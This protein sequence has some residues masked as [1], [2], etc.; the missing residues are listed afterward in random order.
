MAKQTI[1]IGTSD[2]SGDGESIRNAFDKCNDNFTEN[3]ASIASIEADIATLD[4]SK[5][6]YGDLSVTTAA[7]SG[8]GALTYNSATGVFTFTPAASVAETNDLT[9]SVTWAN[10]PDANITESSVTQHQAALTITESQI[11]DLSHTSYDQDLNTTDS[12]QFVG[13]TATGNGT[14]TGTL[15]VTGGTNFTGTTYHNGGLS[16]SNG[17]F[18]GTID[19][20]TIQTS[21]GNLSIIADNYVFIDSDRDGS[22]VIGRNSGVGNVVL[23][24]T[25]NDTDVVF[26]GNVIVKTGIAGLDTASSIAPTSFT[27][28]AGNNTGADLFNAANG[29]SLTLQGGSSGFNPGGALNLFG[30]D[31][32]VDG[33]INIGTSH[34]STINVGATIDMGTNTITDTKVGQWDTAYGWG[35][36]SSAG[37]LS[38]ITVTTD[39]YNGDYNLVFVPGSG[40]KTNVRVDSTGS[41]TWNPNTNVLTLDGETITSTKIGQWDDAYG[42]G[43]H[44]AE[45]YVPSDTAGITGADQVT[46]IVTLTQAEYDAIGS[47]NASTVYIIVG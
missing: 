39:D 29:G 26:E 19:T 43:D 36:H 24:N 4:G 38:A 10:V 47:P 27:I 17:T 5:I 44:S 41:L 1:N 16:S 30:G 40:N 6:V 9:A 15:A 14:I 22:I 31:G 46:N 12:V 8:A 23:G 13:I 45:N 37:Y 7:A 28:R 35:D 11:S 3:Y 34:T 20:N 33:D 2:T 42:W 25:A 18:S 32:S 21:D